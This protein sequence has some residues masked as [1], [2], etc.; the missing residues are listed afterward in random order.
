LGD[1][2]GVEVVEENDEG[3]DETSSSNSSHVGK[4][5]QSE[6]SNHPAVFRAEGREKILMVAKVVSAFPVV[7]IPTIIN[8]SACSMLSKPV[9]LNLYFLY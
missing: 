4:S 8:N 1:L 5:D 9:L 2:L 3:N 7:S 6:L